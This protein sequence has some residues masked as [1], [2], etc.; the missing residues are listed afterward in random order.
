LITKTLKNGDT[1][2]LIRV[3]PISWNPE[4][5]EYLKVVVDKTAKL[6][7]CSPK[8]SWD[9]NKVGAVIMKKE[10]EL[11]GILAYRNQPLIGDDNQK[12][13]QILI[14]GVND[15]YQQH[16]AYRVL[17]KEL[18]DLAKENGYHG[19]LSYVRAKNKNMMNTLK[20]LGKE[21]VTVTCY[22]RL[23]DE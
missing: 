16:G 21:I 2:K 1:V 6:G 10:G 18:E 12:M 22:K 7:F 3:S 8:T 15:E 20:S 17:H 13:L 9:D 14:G 23:D 5:A 4:A 11:I 19:I